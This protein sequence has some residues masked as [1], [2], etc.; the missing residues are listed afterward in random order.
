MP[1]DPGQI[2]PV[3]ALLDVTIYETLSSLSSSV[4]QSGYNLKRGRAP[5]HAGHG[6]FLSGGMARR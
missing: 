5:L 6:L 4:R 2:R 1:H 3:P